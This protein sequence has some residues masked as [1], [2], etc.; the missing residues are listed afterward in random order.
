M[1]SRLPVLLLALAL[2]PTAAFARS[3][4]HYF[5]IGGK[6]AQSGGRVLITGDPDTNK[7]YFFEIHWRCDEDTATLRKAESKLPENHAFA[8]GKGFSFSFKAGKVT[9]TLAGKVNRS[10]GKGVSG[11]GTIKIK[12]PGCTVAKQSWSG[13]GKIH[14]R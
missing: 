13:T 8:F 1:R 3:A 11:K 10:G 9:F 6:T 5:N 12:A 2:V 7:L 14:L 4:G